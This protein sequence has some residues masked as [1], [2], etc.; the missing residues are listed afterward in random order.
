[1]LSEVDRCAPRV[2]VHWL[3]G[4][5]VKSDLGKPDI[6]DGSAIKTGTNEEITGRRKYPMRAIAQESCGLVLVNLQKSPEVRKA[7]K[8][9]RGPRLDAVS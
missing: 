5:G 9:T 1:M 6:R 2:L 3:D 8:V 7:E 4:T